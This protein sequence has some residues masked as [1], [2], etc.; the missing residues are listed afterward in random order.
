MHVLTRSN[1]WV[2]VV[3]P[4]RCGCS[5]YF[6][7]DVVLATEAG[8]AG[9]ARDGGG[10]GDTPQVNEMGLGGHVVLRHRRPQP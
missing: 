6:G 4:L 3:G 7:S 5:P 9:G 10:D 1:G 2:D 8:M